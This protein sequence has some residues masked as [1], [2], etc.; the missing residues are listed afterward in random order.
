MALAIS[1]RRAQQERKFNA[2]ASCSCKR[3]QGPAILVEQSKHM[4]KE[5]LQMVRGRAI[6]LSFIQKIGIEQLPL[7]PWKVSEDEDFIF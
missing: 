4:K 2:F 3:G 7:S 6:E 1:L 5:Q